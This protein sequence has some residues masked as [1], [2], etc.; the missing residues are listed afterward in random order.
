MKKAKPVFEITRK[1]NDPVSLLEI[2]SVQRKVARG[3]EPPKQSLVP[4]HKFLTR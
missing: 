2:I 1:T 4:P 3:K